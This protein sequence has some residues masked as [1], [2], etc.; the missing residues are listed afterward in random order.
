MISFRNII[1]DLLHN[2]YLLCIS[3]HIAFAIFPF[4]YLIQCFIFICKTPIHSINII[5]YTVYCNSLSYLSD[6]LNPHTR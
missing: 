5:I 2:R 3:S 4:F 6:F 1:K